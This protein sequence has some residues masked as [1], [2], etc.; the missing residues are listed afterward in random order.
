MR[1][2]DDCTLTLQQ[3]AK[4]KMEAERALKDANAVGQF[5]TP[6][7]D[8][9]RAANVHEV[10][11][12]V[13]NESFV[14]KL[15]K[16]VGGTLRKALEK[17]IGLFDARSRLVFIDRSLHAVKQTFIKL[18]ETAHG[19]L[20]WQRDMYAIVE[21]SKQNIDPDVADL[22]DREANVFASEVLFQLNGFITEAND[23]EFGIFVPV[24]IGKK[25]G[26]SI[27]ASVRQYVSKNP[28]A[29]AVIVLNPPEPAAGF[30]FKAYLRR[31]IASPPFTEKFGE[32]S[33]PKFFTPDDKIGAMVPIGGR[34]ASN[35]R[36]VILT[37]KNGTEHE[38]I[39]EAFT[40][41]YQVFILILSVK[42]L[43]S[44][45]VLVSNG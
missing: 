38:C 20:S 41:T 43:T 36:E 14:A 2:P 32:L 17:V 12:D 30:G 22:F 10:E 28:K 6:V 13:L 44:T 15:R 4:I 40:Q 16:E 25:Y 1:K 27:Y 11:E 26:A 23:H 34:K 19:F 37:D 8:I 18:H 45:T 42:A 33:L 29:C 24:R 5:P 21:D 3:Y 9:M 35:K 31:V 39:G 7:P